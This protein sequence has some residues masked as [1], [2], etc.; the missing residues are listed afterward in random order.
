[1]IWVIQKQSKCPCCKKEMKI[2]SK[3]SLN[4][5]DV[6]KRVSDEFS[7]DP[8]CV[9]CR[10]FMDMDEYGYDPEWEICKVCIWNDHSQAPRVLCPSCIHTVEGK[11]AGRF[12]DFHDELD[13]EKFYLYP[14]HWNCNQCEEK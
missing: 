4:G 1:M 14:D 9:V 6:V 8:R 11:K 3:K 5:P 2:I 7:D 12:T 13:E 10:N